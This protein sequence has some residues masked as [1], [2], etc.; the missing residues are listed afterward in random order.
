MN[1]RAGRLDNPKV[2]AGFPWCAVLGRAPLVGIQFR[3]GGFNDFG[4]FLGRSRLTM[5]TLVRPARERLDMACGRVRFTSVRGANDGSG[6]QE[7]AR[8]AS[9]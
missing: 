8:W 1:I 4:T 7:E 9:E 6:R 3:L 5:A 2:V